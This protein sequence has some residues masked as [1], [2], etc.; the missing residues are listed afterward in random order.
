MSVDADCSRGRDH[1][2]CYADKV[3]DQNFDFHR[4]NKMADFRHL[5]RHCS[6]ADQSIMN[7]S[8]NKF[9]ALREAAVS[10][11]TQFLIFP[12]AKFVLL[13]DCKQK[14]F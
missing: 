12:C 9:H 4:H 6:Y 2:R 14:V 7:Q 1:D 5:P 3:V 13:C 8:I 10:N 11:S